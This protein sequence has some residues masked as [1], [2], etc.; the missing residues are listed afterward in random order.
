MNLHHVVFA[1]PVHVA[2]QNRVF[3]ADGRQHSRLESAISVAQHGGNRNHSG[4][5]SV[6]AYHIL[7]TAHVVPH[8]GEQVLLAIPVEVA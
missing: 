7:G 1:V 3:I 4:K 8:H 5:V 6:A 2:H